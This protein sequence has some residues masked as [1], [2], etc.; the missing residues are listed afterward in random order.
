MTNEQIL[1]KAIEQA[2]ENGWKPNSIQIVEAV[3]KYMETGFYYHIVFDLAFAKAFWGEY[4]AKECDNGC[5]QYE[6][7]IIDK[8]GHWHYGWKY[9]LQQ[10]VLSKDPINYLEKYLKNE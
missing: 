2:V 3:A 5:K 10:M 6:S 1:K 9:H 4:V 8:L 7:E